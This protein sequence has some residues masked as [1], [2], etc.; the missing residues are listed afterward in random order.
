MASDCCEARPF[1]KG[2]RF[3]RRDSDVAFSKCIG[4]PDT[5]FCA[6]DTL[7]SCWVRGNVDVC[8]A[9]DSGTVDYPF[10][11]SAHK[12]RFE[13]NGKSKGTLPYIIKY[14]FVGAVE[15]VETEARFLGE[16]PWERTGTYFIDVYSPSCLFS[17]D[18]SC[19]KSYVETFTVW[20][21]KDRWFSQLTDG[22]DESE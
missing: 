17:E 12:T 4:K 16:Q 18:S 19:S 15:F 10:A 14:K 13:N 22:L 2:E 9:A 6:I 20:R 8:K 21:G 3:V 11:F 5:P 7:L 1:P